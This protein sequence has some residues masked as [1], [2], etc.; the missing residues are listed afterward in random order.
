[1]TTSAASAPLG[2]LARYVTVGAA[3][4]AISFAAYALLIAAAVP[5]EAAAALA[6]AAGAVN[7]YVLNRRWTFAAADSARARTAYVCVQGAGALASGALVW[8]LVHEAGAGGLGA[9]VVAVPPITLATFLA[10]RFWTFRR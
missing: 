10:N 9:Y 5:S 1:M 7:G 2:Q 4:T 6:F 3:N 8:V